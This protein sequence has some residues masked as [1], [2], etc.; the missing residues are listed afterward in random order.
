MNQE[1]DGTILVAIGNLLCD[2]HGFIE[3]VGMGK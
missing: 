3:M 2:I 1:L